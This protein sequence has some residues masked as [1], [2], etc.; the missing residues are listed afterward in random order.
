MHRLW[1]MRYRLRHRRLVSRPQTITGSTK[2]SYQLGQGVYEAGTG[3]QEDVTPRGDS[4]NPD[5]GAA[6]SAHS[7]N[8]LSYSVEFMIREP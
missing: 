4:R 2:G 6:S 5:R 8:A 1:V 7:S 3:A